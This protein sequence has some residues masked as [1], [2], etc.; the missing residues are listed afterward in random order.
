MNK[1]ELKNR[2]S[3]IIDSFESSYDANELYDDEITED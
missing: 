2:L 1:T 3:K